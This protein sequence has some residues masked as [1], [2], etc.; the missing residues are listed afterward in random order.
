MSGLFNAANTY[1]RSVYLV[2]KSDG[3]AVGDGRGIAHWDGAQWTVIPAGY[4]PD[5]VSGPSL[6]AVRMLA[7]N[8]GWAVGQDGMI[9]RYTK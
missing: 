6:Y 7:S 8:S 9:L 1:Y 2:S 3:W 4:I 5:I